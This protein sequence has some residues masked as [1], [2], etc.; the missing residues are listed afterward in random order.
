MIMIIINFKNYV[1][2][3]EA[4][5]LA[6]KIEK[7][8]PGAI[9]CPSFLDVE[10]IVKKTGLRVFAQHLSVFEG[11][12]TT[13]F[14]IP[15]SVK[16]AGG[17]GTLLNHSEHRLTPKAIG[18][19]VRNAD[20]MKLK[21]ILCV[22]SLAETKK[23]KKLK[24]WAIAYEDEKLIGSGK[25]IIDFRTD[26]VKKFVSL[27]KG[28]GIISLCGAGISSVEDFKTAK[29]LGCRGVLIASAI[30]GNKNSGKLLKKL[31]IV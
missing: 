22:A 16:V 2:A 12:K 24:P 19:S 1:F 6:R 27:L 3:D 29:K 9:I 7:Y 10:E 21:V 14:V 20:K 11:S 17:T 5:K 26:D 23:Y 4:V 30:V 31:S 13:G 25:S 15:E 18:Q 8:L 28:S